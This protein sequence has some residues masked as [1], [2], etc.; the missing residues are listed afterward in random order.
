MADSRDPRRQVF[1]NQRAG[2]NHRAFAY[3]QMIDDERIQELKIEHQ[4]L[5]SQI[6][7]EISRPAP[8]G[9]IVNSLKRQKLKIKDELASLGAA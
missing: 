5:E 6:D 8:D 4:N 2:A 7:N 1:E 3:A 9:T